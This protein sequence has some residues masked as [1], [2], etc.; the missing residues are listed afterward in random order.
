MNLSV[1]V[2]IVQ[3]AWKGAKFGRNWGM[4]GDVLIKA[5]LWG[6]RR[7]AGALEPGT[8]LRISPYALESG[9]TQNLSAGVIIIRN[10]IRKFL[11]EIY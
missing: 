4:A 10:I 6:T 9:L 7:G 1:V 3:D 8:R 11:L 2:V 5:E